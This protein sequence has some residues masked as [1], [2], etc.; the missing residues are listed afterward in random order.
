MQN[1]LKLG[2]VDAVGAVG[3]MGAM[4]SAVLI[5]SIVFSNGNSLEICFAEIQWK[6]GFAEIQ[7]KFAFGE[8]RFAEI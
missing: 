7:L 2:V 4:G 1:Y 3:A 6:F 5:T 8:I